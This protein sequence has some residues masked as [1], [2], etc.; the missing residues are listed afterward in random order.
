MSLFD[1]IK[2]LFDKDD[3]HEVKNQPVENNIPWFSP[4]YALDY[5]KN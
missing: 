1:G 4:R 5:E 3:E 2:N